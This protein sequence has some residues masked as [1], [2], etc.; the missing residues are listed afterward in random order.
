M[1]IL[2]SSDGKTITMT[3]GKQQL[4]KIS[5]SLAAHLSSGKGDE[6][7]RDMLTEIEGYLT[8]HPD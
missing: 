6:D 5:T 3:L 7:E 8:R 2:E 1:L 4:F